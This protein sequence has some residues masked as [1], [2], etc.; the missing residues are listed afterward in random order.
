MALLDCLKTSIGLSRTICNCYDTGK[1]ADF[2]VS[3]SGFY[4][5]ELEGLN[6]NMVKAGE[7]CADGN[8][9]Q[10]MER[11]RENAITNIG[12]DI[13]A[14]LAMTT[15]T[16][17]PTYT[18]IIGQIEGKADLNV[19]STYGGIKLDG[20]KIRGGEIILKGISTLMNATGTIDVEIRNSWNDDV[21]Q[22]NNLNTLQDKVQTNA[23]G[24]PIVLDLDPDECDDVEYYIT[25]D[26]TQGV[27]PKNNAVRCNCSKENA[28]RQYFAADG[29]ETDD[30][31]NV[32]NAST[33]NAS[34]AY[35]LILDLQVRC[36]TH[37]LIC[38]DCPDYENDPIAITIA[39]A[40]QYKAAEIL[41][42]DVLASGNINRYTLM[43]SELM[44]GL[45]DKYLK[46]YIDRVGWIVDN[47]DISNN[48]CL[49]CED[50]SITVGKI[51]V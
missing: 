48:D 25:Y 7:D 11:A 39:K 21:I 9:W 23:L 5:D 26:M 12:S 40:I 51:L 6:I 46:E 22:I 16:R 2:D 35:G 13:L 47:T 18:G 37:E 50:N 49:V 24:T 45:T 8:L 1:P 4:L 33:R 43:S 27:A 42:I 14:G 20:K 29:I 31:S 10:K 3:D 32:E 41:L 19:I 44:L 28:W 30:L 17:R 38:H 34:K 15:K 36:K